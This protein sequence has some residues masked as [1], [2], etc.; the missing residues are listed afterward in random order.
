MNPYTQLL[1]L[2]TST[3]P[4]LLCTQ[5]EMVE[6]LLSVYHLGE[7]LSPG[8]VNFLPYNKTISDQ[9]AIVQSFIDDDDQINI[10]TDY[11]EPDIKSNSIAYH[12]IKGMIVADSYWYFS[13]KQFE[14]DLLAADANPNINVHFLHIK[15]GGGEAWYL[16]QI[17]KTL[18]SLKKPIYSYIEKVGASAAYYIGVHGQIIKA[19]TQN[20]TIGSIG[21]MVDGL[22]I[23]SYFEKIGMTRIRALATKSDLKNK[24]FEDLRENKP[25]Q[26][27]K[28]EL[29]PLQQQFESEIRSARPSLN[30]LDDQDPVFRGETF[31]ANLAIDKKLIDGIATFP[32]ALVEANQMGLDY[33]ATINKL[34]SISSYL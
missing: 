16:D 15:S 2:L 32:E 5:D 13:T 20:D 11:S 1:S 12:P 22:D 8:S 9:L 6:A 7:T 30:T 31:S 29:D 4:R 17:S 23:M 26:F 3:T 18:S 24:K 19:M 10:T 33:A 34:R 27:I 14:R 28:E 21:T 25:E